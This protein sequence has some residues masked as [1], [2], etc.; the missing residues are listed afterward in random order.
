MVPRHNYTTYYLTSW[1]GGAG[2][3]FL[4]TRC[5]E[6]RLSVLAEGKYGVGRIHSGYVCSVPPVDVDDHRKLVILS[7]RRLGP[8]NYII[9]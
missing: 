2:L 5:R 3:L 8:G 4:F 9:T 1:S 6:G 7:L